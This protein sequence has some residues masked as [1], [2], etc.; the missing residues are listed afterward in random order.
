MHDMMKGIM[1]TTTT[2]TRNTNWKRVKT[3]SVR[4]G[5]AEKD[6]GGT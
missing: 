1:K 2:H 5:G 6:G 3:I 4:F